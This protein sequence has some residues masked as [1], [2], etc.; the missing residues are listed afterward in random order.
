MDDV[1]TIF[2]KQFFKKMPNHL[3]EWVKLDDDLKKALHLIQ[4]SDY[5][6]KHHIRVVMDSEKT[7]AVAFCVGEKN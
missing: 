6:K 4:V 2:N 7:H 5:K 1:D 3:D